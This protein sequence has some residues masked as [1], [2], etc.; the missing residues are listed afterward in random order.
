MGGG[1]RKERRFGG[2]NAGYCFV[3]IWCVDALFLLN[4]K[5]LQGKFNTPNEETNNT[6]IKSVSLFSNHENRQYDGI[7]SRFHKVA[8]TFQTFSNNAEQTDR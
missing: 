6:G 4:T 3:S 5:I 1:A 2:W 7:Y 8:H